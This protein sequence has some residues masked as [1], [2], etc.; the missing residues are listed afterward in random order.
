MP[1]MTA[2]AYRR[3]RLPS[4]YSPARA[5]GHSYQGSIVQHGR[6]IAEEIP[7]QASPNLAIR[8]MHVVSCSGT[9]PPPHPRPFWLRHLSGGEERNLTP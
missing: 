1:A 2:S 9:V 4:C 6:T 8:A 5:T 7:S 3:A